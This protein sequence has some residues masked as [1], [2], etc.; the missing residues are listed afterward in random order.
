V[1]RDR[2]ELYP[3]RPDLSD[4]HAVEFIP[5]WWLGTN[6]SRRSIREIIDL[7]L[8]IA[9]VNPGDVAPAVGE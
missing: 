7:A 6:Y 5:G 1:A 8:E 2:T 3:G 4:G 9:G